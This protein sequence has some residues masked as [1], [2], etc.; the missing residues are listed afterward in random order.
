MYR[1]ACR[2]SDTFVEQQQTMAVTSS[3]AAAA[4]AASPTRRAH[5]GARYYQTCR[6]PFLSIPLS[7][8]K[9]DTERIIR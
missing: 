4:A 1:S 9:A 5:D 6:G 7:Q 3:A 2:G 8:A